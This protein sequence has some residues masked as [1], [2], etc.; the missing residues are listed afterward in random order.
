MSYLKDR[1]RLLGSRAIDLN[2]TADQSFV[3][4][5]GKYI[6]QFIWVTDPSI[7][8][9]ASPAAGGIY[10]AASKGG[11]A[12]VG[13][14]QVYTALT[15]AGK[16]VLLTIALPNDVFSAR[17]LYFSLTTAHGSAA[18]GNLWFFGAALDGV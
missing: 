14:G 13:A 6:P 11:L 18:T 10:T 8:F 12:I 2:S 15:A 1:Y 9:T 5:S 7:D 17:T 4:S 3:V 16:H